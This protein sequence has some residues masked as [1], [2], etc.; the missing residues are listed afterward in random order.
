MIIKKDFKKHFELILQVARNKSPI[1]VKDTMLA[2]I[3]I[4]TVILPLFSPPLSASYS[5][6]YVNNSG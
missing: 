3:G 6:L 1:G 4:K 2:L 5:Y